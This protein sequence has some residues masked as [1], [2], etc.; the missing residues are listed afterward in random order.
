MTAMAFLKS[1]MVERLDIVENCAPLVEAARLFFTPEFEYAKKSMKAR[2]IIDDF[3]GYVRF[4]DEKYDIIAMDHSIEDPYAI[5]FFTVEFFDQLK[6]ISKPGAVVMMLGKGL[7]WNTT[8]M[9]FKYIYKNINPEIEPALRSGCL[10]MSQSEFTGPSAKDYVL[11]KEGL[12]MQDDVY[13]DE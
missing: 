11:V 6:R 2:N 7:S 8:R 12:R 4:A 1:P 10:Y 3:R 13:S 5:G 9:S